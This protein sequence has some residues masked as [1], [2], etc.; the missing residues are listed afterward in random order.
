MRDGGV[1]DI[2]GTMILVGVTVTLVAV[3]SIQFGFGRPPPAEVPR[4]DIRVTARANDSF[5]T[6]V[7]TGG[8]TFDQ[9]DIR[10]V[11]VVGPTSVFD[12][13]LGA[14]GALWK[15]G[16]SRQVGPLPSA[17]VAGDRASLTLVS[18]SRG[19]TVATTALDVPST[20]AT[21]PAP[22][23]GFAVAVG[24][25]GGGTSGSIEPPS[26]LLVTASVLHPQG[27]RA[28]V[29]VEANVTPL[30]DSPAILM[31][32]DGTQGDE[33][34][35]D[36]NFA[37]FVLVLSGASPGVKDL[38]VTATDL[39]GAT[40]TG[41][42]TVTVLAPAESVVVLNSTLVERAAFRV[43]KFES[44]NS[45][46]VTV[47]VKAKLAAEPVTIDGATW[48]LD[49]A[50]FDPGAFKPGQDPPIE[51]ALLCYDSTSRVKVFGIGNETINSYD[52][53][54]NV[55]SF[56]INLQ[57]RRTTGS[58]TFDTA[59]SSGAADEQFL[60]RRTDTA[61]VMM[62]GTWPTEFTDCTDL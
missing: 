38:V 5:M 29:G 27:R 19:A 21:T 53:D 35:G 36:G 15:L 39:G 43:L 45:D 44:G 2:I 25:Q 55:L 13:T 37:A 14:S 26:S 62:D 17:L 8:D 12:G 41:T 6:L 9:G 24:L 20:S 4:L 16:D 52:M 33:I 31:R 57:W 54:R 23:A 59:I 60:F 7:H 58:E 34:A 18:V 56:F 32:D 40:V 47:H 22:P 48:S 42:G 28:V 10:V 46:K 49:K 51:L 50:F 3:A 11:A 61:K 1:S 30:A